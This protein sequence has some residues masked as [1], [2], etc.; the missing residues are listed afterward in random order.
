[1]PHPCGRSSRSS[2]KAS[3]LNA[4]SPEEP[5]RSPPASPRRKAIATRAQPQAQWPMALRSARRISVLRSLR[6]RQRRAR[7]IRRRQQR[8]WRGSAKA[9][10]RTGSRAAMFTGRDGRT[11]RTATMCKPGWSFLVTSTGSLPKNA[12]PAAVRR[13]AIAS[14]QEAS[15]DGIP[16]DVEGKNSGKAQTP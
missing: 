13:S 15:N 11:Y 12:R 2:P 14:I 3:P 16:G 5:S 7:A 6:R 10:F 9:I 8:S 1:M 4:A